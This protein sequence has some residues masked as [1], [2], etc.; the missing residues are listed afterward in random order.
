MQKLRKSVL[1]VVFLLALY[2]LLRLIFYKL[3]FISNNLP[4]AELESVFYWGLRTDIT[5]IFYSNLVFFVYYF[6]FYDILFARKKKTIA[7][8]LLSVINL[9][10]LAVNIIDL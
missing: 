10:L 5:G 6:L 2:A 9:P 4:T 7:V 3:Y 1:I 8:L